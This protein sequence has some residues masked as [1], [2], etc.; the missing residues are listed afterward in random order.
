MK[1]YA[2]S[3][4]LYAIIAM[5]C[6]AFYFGFTWYMMYED[7]TALGEVHSHYLLY[8][9]APC[10]LLLLLQ[11][12]FT[13][14]EQKAVKPARVLLAL[15]LNLVGLHLLAKG[16]IEVLYYSTEVWMDYALLG[17]AALGYVLMGLAALLLLVS[18]ARQVQARLTPPAGQRAARPHRAQPA[19]PPAAAPAPAVPVPP[20]EV[21]PV[22]QE[23][24]PVVQEVQPVVQEAQPVPQEAPTVSE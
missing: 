7:A 21:Q 22:A 2:N 5:L 19:H 20:Q 8:G 23:V 4:L 15:G 3:A 6:G 17:A 1:R 18:V 16:L 12:T 11:R 10:L 24:Q 9:V 14:S 13:I